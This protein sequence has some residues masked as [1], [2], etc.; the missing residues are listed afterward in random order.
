MYKGYKVYKG[1]TQ[2]NSIKTN[3]INN[4][5][6]VGKSISRLVSIQYLLC[7]YTSGKSILIKISLL[8]VYIL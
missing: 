8:T 1:G 6:Y 7:L 2:F 4:V 3:L 5:I